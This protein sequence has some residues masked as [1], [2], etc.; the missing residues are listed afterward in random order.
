MSPFG[1]S[2]RHGIYPQ[3][4]LSFARNFELISS[5]P[6]LMARQSKVDFCWIRCVHS[7][8]AGLSDEERIALSWMARRD[9]FNS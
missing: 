7:I 5:I 2:I 4:D 8:K 1:P 9:R 3:V 6:D